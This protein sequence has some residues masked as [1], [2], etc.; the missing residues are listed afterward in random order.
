LLLTSDPLCFSFFVDGVCITADCTQ[1]GKDILQH[2][3]KMD[4]VMSNSRLIAFL[5]HLCIDV[6]DD[7][8]DVFKQIHNRMTTN[9]QK[10]YH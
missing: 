8:L 5:A 1:S 10:S 3:K 2:V 6:F 7:T 9:S 4:L